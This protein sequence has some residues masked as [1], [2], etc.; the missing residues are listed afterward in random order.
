MH[1]IGLP[2]DIY[3]FFLLA[4]LP[5]MAI[6]SARVFNAPAPA[7]GAPR[8]RPI[9]SRATMFANTSVMLVMLF[10]LAWFTA[11]SFGY[12]IFAYETIG[13]REL[14][15]GLVALGVMVA[16]IPVSRMMR[17]AEA[18][19][20]APIN[21]MMPQNPHET[22]IYSLMAVIA[23]IS[24]EAAYRGVLTQILWYALGNP[25]LAMF[26]AAVAFAVVHGIQGWKSA[27]LVFVIACLMHALVWF[28]GTLVIAMFVHAIYDLAVPT[29]RRKISLGLPKDLER[30][31]G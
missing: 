7:D 24:E 22:A 5:F 18:L 29:L 2:S 13:A 10:L 21:R 26:I 4:F 28:T 20:N 14:L 12:R 27:L 3:L 11:R 23:G 17:T 30:S 9:P 15:A 8:K 1:A 16:L 19:R 31:A 6:R 25:W